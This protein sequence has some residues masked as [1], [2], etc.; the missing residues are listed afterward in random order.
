MGTVTVTTFTS[1]TETVTRTKLN[2]LA[3][4][5][6]TEFN[7]SIDKANVATDIALSK[8]ASFADG[9]LSSGVLT[10]TH[11]LSRQYVNVTI[12]DNNDIAVEPDAVTATSTSV[13][14]VD[15]SSFDTLSGTWNYRISI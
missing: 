12:Y 4:N 2:G 8:A 13:T 5:I 15:L 3:A 1:D 7:G 6:L 14:T 10:I 11:S 9:D